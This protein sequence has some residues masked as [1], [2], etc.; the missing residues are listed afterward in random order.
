[1]S[2]TKH[3]T[4]CNPHFSVIMSFLVE[5]L[6]WRN[7]EIQLIILQTL[8]VKTFD[9][10]QTK[11]QTGEWNI[12]NTFELWINWF[13]KFKFLMNLLSESNQV[14]YLPFS[15]P[16][17]GSIDFNTDSTTCPAGMYF[18]TH[19]LVWI[20]D[21][22]ILPRVEIYCVTHSLWPQDFLRPSRCLSR[23][24]GNLLVV[25]DVQPNTSL[26]LADTISSQVS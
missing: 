19:P 20:N 24:S 11:L 17:Q 18:L 10:S 13:N 15:H 23:A 9:Q 5:N 6:S 2:S 8:K 26:L 14:Q 3:N 21:E 1:M 22:R 25:G 4:C 16:W 12:W 7:I